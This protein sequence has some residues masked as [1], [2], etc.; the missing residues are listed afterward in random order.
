MKEFT[1]KSIAEPGNATVSKTGNQL[2]NDRINSQPLQYIS[3]KDW[4]Y[5]LPNGYVI[6]E[7]KEI[8]ITPMDEIFFQKVSDSIER[9]MSNSEFSVEQ[10]GRESGFSRMQLYRKLKVLTGESPNEFIRTI[11]LKR[12]AQLIKQKQLTIKEVTYDVGFSDLKYFRDCFR[13]IFGV[14]PSEFA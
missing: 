14:N 10:L 7:P 4:Q 9:N 2:I 3:E 5:R 6:I 11:R 8:T 1:L 13:E 12:A